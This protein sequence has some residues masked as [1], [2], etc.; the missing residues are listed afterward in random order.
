MREVLVSVTPADATIERDGASLGES[1]VAI[2]LAEGEEATL[3][4][5]RKGY[6]TKTATLSG[7]EPKQAFALEAV[8]APAARPAAAAPKPPSA[9]GGIDDVGD[10]FAKKH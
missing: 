6:K 7:A 2:H 10:P 8:A 3:V 1:P 5:S 9:L 4:I